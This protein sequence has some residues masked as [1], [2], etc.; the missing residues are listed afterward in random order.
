MAFISIEGTITRSFFENKGFEVTEPAFT[1]KD[2]KEIA[3]RYTLWFNEPQDLAVGDQGV[4]S[5]VHSSKID[6]YTN[7]EGELKTIVVISV[8]NA[9]AKTVAKSPE[10]AGV[11]PAREIDEDDVRKYGLP[12]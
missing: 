4:F 6:T 3:N 5:G 1:T 2:G 11:T 10:Q 8:N 12:F 7:K 9:K